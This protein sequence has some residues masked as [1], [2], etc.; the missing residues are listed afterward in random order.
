MSIII[1]EEKN[2]FTLQTKSTSY[3]MKVDSYGLLLHTYYGKKI[4]V[5]DMSYNFEKDYYL[6]F[7]PYDAISQPWHPH[8][9]DMLPQE[10][11]TYGNGDFRESAINI[12]QAD[13]SLGV[14]LRYD[15]FKVEDKKYTLSGLPSFYGDNAQTLVITLKDKIYDGKWTTPRQYY[16]DG[17]NADW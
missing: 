6:S 1:N 11:S 16:E 10:I 8:S 15:S 9:V 7:S 4:P 14:E 13:G 3:Q 5:A 12:R 17:S 2:I